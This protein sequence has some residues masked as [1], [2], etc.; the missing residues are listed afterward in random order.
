MIVQ[1]L[2]AVGIADVA[3]ALGSDGVISFAVGADGGVVPQCIGIAEQRNS[4][5]PVALGLGIE[6]AKLH[7]GWIKHGQVDR[8]FAAGTGLRHA[9][10]SDDEWNMIGFFPQ[11]EFLNVILLADVKTVVRPEDNDRVLG[12]GAL[13]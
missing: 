11:R 1:F 6:S 5:W 9:R 2:R 4:A 7:Q 8:L 10:C 13:V 3:P 12:D